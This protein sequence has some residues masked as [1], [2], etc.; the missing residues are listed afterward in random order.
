MALN[1]SFC[2]WEKNL[3]GAQNVLRNSENGPW[4][5]PPGPSALQT[6][7]PFGQKKKV[8]KNTY[9]ISQTKC[10]KNYGSSVSKH[11]FGNFFYVEQR[12]GT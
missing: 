6:L 10:E 7:L 8:E 9:S 5:G 4:R 3:D 11:L 12:A 1:G 2:T